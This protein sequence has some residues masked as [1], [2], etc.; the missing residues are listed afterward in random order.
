MA[1]TRDFLKIIFS[2]LKNKHRQTTQEIKLYY[3]QNHFA[4][5]LILYKGYTCISQPIW[6]QRTHNQKLNVNVSRGD[7]SHRFSYCRLTM[8]GKIP[9]HYIGSTI[10]GWLMIKDH[11]RNWA[12]EPLVPNFHSSFPFKSNEISNLYEGK[13]ENQLNS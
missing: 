1:P 3:C 4:K 10:S 6:D 2:F 12:V 13:C 11:V 8:Q 5:S 9:V 7:L